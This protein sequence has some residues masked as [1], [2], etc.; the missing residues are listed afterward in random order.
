MVLCL[1]ALARAPVE[2]GEAA[3]AVGDDRLHATLP[4]QLDGLTVTI[5]AGLDLSRLAGPRDLAQKARDIGLPAS[6]ASCSAE[7]ERPGGR[8]QR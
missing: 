4:C 1:L 3:V 7:V 8:G 6:F 5:F 2:L